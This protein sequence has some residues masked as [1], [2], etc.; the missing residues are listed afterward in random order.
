MVAKKP[1]NPRKNAMIKWAI[2]IPE[3]DL[4]KLQ[5]TAGRLGKTSAALARE[6]IA[7]FNAGQIKL[8]MNPHVKEV[9][10]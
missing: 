8:P 10:K 5:T 3:P 7:A 6:L 9:Y 1:K 4:D 2:A